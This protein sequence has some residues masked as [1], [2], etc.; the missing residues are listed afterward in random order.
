[1]VQSDVWAS[2]AGAGGRTTLRILSTEA[3]FRLGYLYIGGQSHL[4][5]YFDFEVF[6]WATSTEVGPAELDAR[7]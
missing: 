5:P 1:M 7:L 2:E 6:D 3:R 4:C